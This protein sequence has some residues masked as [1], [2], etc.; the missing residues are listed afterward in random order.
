MATPKLQLDRNGRAVLETV[1]LRK[2]VHGAVVETAEQ[3]FRRVARA[4]ALGDFLYAQPG[5]VKKLLVRHQRAEHEFG[6]LVLHASELGRAV[7][8]DKDVRRVEEEF[9]DLLVSLDFV[10][11]APVLF[12]AGKTNQFVSCVGLAVQDD[13]HALL[14]ALELAV[15]LQ[16]FGGSVGISFRSLR[17]AGSV[18]SRTQGSS[19]GVLGFLRLFDGVVREIE[20]GFVRPGVMGALLPIDHADIERFIRAR[21]SGA[22]LPHFALTVGV[23]DAFVRAVQKGISF[24]LVDPHT[25]RAVSRVDARVLFRL[26]CES[27]HLTG[28]P[29]LVFSDECVRASPLLKGE[30]FVA[31]APSLEMPLLQHQPAFLGSIN[32]AQMV[33]NGVLDKERLKKRVWQAIH[34]L[35]NMIDVSDYASVDI[36]AQAHEYRAVGLGV[37]GFADMLFQMNIKYNSDASLRA[38]EEVMSFIHAEATAASVELARTRGVFPVHA[39]SVYAQKKVRLRVRNAVRTMIAPGF[40]ASMIAGCSP[41]VQAVYGLVH[42]VVLSSGQEL[43]LVNPWFVDAA[44]KE[45]VYSDHLLSKV[46]LTGTVKGTF[47]PAGLKKIFVTVFD[48]DP[49]WH[50]RV[51]AAFQKHCDGGVAQTVVFPH[52]ATVDDI[53]NACLRA[54]ELHCR[55]FAARRAGVRSQQACGFGKHFWVAAEGTCATCG[56]AGLAR[57]GSCVFCMTCGTVSHHS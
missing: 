32:L 29:S 13:L 20:P 9:Y 56:A 37:M 11:S 3:L 5:L 15:G 43:R 14:Q 30:R 51:Q 34:F 22:P 40:M 1:F 28:G 12:T 31:V 33:K 48:V 6:W 55:G 38:A 42:D 8:K 19:A 23:S 44:H 53:M 21:L 17:R 26:L 57:E 41:G 4:V 50:V 36:L 45:K 7:Q 18:V 35:D 2:N 27:I 47:M 39:R 16:Q 46:R 24:P 49:E 25:R 52:D 54:Y 10:P